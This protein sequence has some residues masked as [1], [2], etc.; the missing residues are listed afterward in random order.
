[1]KK[2]FIAAIVEGHGE[3]QAVPLLLQRIITK[4]APDVR[5]E[6]NPPLRVKAGRFTTDKIYFA[7]Y[8][9]LAARKAKARENGSV[10]ILLDSEDACPAELGPRLAERARTVRPDVPIIVTLAYREYETWF[11]GA[12]RS[13]RG[14]CGLPSNLEP[15]VNPEATRDA[16]GWLAAHMPRGYIETSDQS[17]FTSHFSLDEARRLLSFARFLR[18]VGELCT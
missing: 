16:K 11:L 17:T 10:L 18:R 15:P 6:V 13:L 12:A 7:S 1:M 4:V 8:L 3:V 9:E 5:L 14:V 2:L